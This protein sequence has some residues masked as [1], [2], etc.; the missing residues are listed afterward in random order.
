MKHK[1]R[2]ASAPQEFNFAAQPI[3]PA[4][5]RTTKITNRPVITLPDR[6]CPNCGRPFV[7]AWGWLFL[8]SGLTLDLCVPCSRTLRHGNAQE[9][10]AL[11]ATIWARYG[12]GRAAA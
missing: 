5:S 7:A 12:G 8:P 2:G 10:R 1:T 4:E 9:Q 11:L 3:T 6:P